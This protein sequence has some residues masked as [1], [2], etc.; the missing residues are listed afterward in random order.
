MSGVAER[1]GKAALSA[2]GSAVS[3]VGSATASVAGAVGAQVVKYETSTVIRLM[4][5]LNVINGIA[6]IICGVVML[7]AVA[8]C[9]GNNQCNGPATA[10]IS[11]YLV[12]FGFML[13]AYEARV[14]VVYERFF[15]K[16]FGFMFGYWG[17]FFFVLFLASLTL[18]IVNTNFALWYVPLLVGIFTAVNAM[19]NCF[20]IRSHPGFQSGEAQALEERGIEFQPGG[21]LP[22]HSSNEPMVGMGGVSNSQ[23][24]TSTSSSGSAYSMNS[25]GNQNADNPFA[26]S[27]V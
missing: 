14:G 8:T 11:F 2:T 15:R 25:R 23:A 10:I 4:R 3:A 27:H 24:P 17:R 21:A 12:L 22:T 1:A 16:Y 13:F 9:S 20:I 6:L 5:V 7:M 19:L 26:V 18:G